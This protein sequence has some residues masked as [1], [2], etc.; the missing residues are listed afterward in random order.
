MLNFT[1]IKSQKSARVTIYNSDGKEVGVC[2]SLFGAYSYFD[3]LSRDLD[4]KSVT[5]TRT[6]HDDVILV[7]VQ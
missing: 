4:C 5:Y 3:G 2:S 6:N 7:K 1:I